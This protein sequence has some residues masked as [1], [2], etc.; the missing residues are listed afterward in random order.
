VNS[1]SDPYNTKTKRLTSLWKIK[2]TKNR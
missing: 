1:D 2:Q